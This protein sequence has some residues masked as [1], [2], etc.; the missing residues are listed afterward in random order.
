MKHRQL[1]TNIDEKCE[2]SSF[3]QSLRLWLSRF[4]S[5]PVLYKKI[6]SA[7]AFQGF[8]GN[9][10]AF[11]NRVL[12]ALVL[13]FVVAPLSEV[14]Y[15][16]F[17]KSA[18][19]ITWY[20]GQHWITYEGVRVEGWYF[21]NFWALFF[22]LGPHIQD[23]VL[24]TAAFLMMPLTDKHGNNDPRRWLLVIA[25]GYPFAKILWTIQIGSDAEIHQIVPASFILVGGLVGFFWLFS[26]NYLMNLHHHKILGPLSTAQGLVDCPDMSDSDKLKNLRP[27]LA[28][29]RA[30]LTGQGPQ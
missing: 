9:L 29:L 21:M 18:P 27:K 10:S 19:I 14:A 11:N 8:A 13:L 16:A 26:F 25:T 3:W 23:V 15:M 2:E 12:V 6:K 20:E 22:Q 5:A 1:T 17:D 4:T 30:R 24:L 28:Q 7:P